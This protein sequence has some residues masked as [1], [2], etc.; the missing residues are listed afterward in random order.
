MVIRSHKEV[1]NKVNE[2]DKIPK[3][4]ENDHEI[5]KEDDSSTSPI[6]STI[7][8]TY[9]PRSPYPQTLD[10]PFPS[11]KAKQRDDMLDL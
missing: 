4:I 3:I 6:E 7:I 10:A 11:K 2:H 5:D 1:D 8:V 9:K